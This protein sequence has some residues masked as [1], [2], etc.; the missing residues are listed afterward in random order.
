MKS[1]MGSKGIPGPQHPANTQGQDSYLASF[2]QL[3]LTLFLKA[4]VSSPKGRV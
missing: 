2:Q 3:I 1:V 4:S